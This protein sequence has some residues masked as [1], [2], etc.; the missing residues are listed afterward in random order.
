MRKLIGFLAAGAFL[1]GSVGVAQAKLTGFHGT[2]TL[3]L[4]SLPPITSTGVVGV[5][6]AI[7]NNSA[8]GDHLYT[9]RINIGGVISELAIVPLTDPGVAPLVSLQGTAILGTGTLFS[10]SG[11]AASSNPISGVLPVGGQF[12]LCILFSGCS[13]FLPLPLSVGG[14]R[15]VGIGGLITVGT[16]QPG[17]KVSV[18][19]NP[20][21]IKTA[22]VSN[23][24]TVNGGFSTSSAF[25]FAHGP[26]SLTS[27]TAQVSGVVQ[28]VTP[29][30]V[31]TTFAGSEVLALMG[32]LRIHFVPEP[33]TALLFGAGIVALGVGGARRRLK[34]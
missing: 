24:P 18:F 17:I 33:G 9:M 1:L 2:L 10:I 5:G 30:L 6:G 3:S 7:L 23:I 15:G 8:G 11:G 4:G 13:S 12:R 22:V 14:T 27:S 28:L 29:I 32:V 20:W 31:N 26:A 25:G 16:F 19:N 21:T 34:K